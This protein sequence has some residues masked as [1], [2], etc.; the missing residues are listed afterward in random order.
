AAA[1]AV[2][3]ATTAAVATVAAAAA[4]PA[5]AAAATAVTGAAA[6][7]APAAPG[8]DGLAAA[9]QGHHEDHT[10]HRTHLLQ[11]TEN[12]F[13]T[14]RVW[15]RPQ[16]RSLKGT[17]ISDLP[18]RAHRRGSRSVRSASQSLSGPLDRPAM[19]GPWQRPAWH[20]PVASA[21]EAPGAARTE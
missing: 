7:A 2:A 20:L 3:V 12:T 6:V 11:R 1:P 13:S 14:R 4:A 16:R 9:R 10:I 5:A 8:L 17:G 21:E 19:V 15:V 18:S